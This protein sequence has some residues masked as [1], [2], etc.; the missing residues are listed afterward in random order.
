MAYQRA[1]LKN[2]QAKRKQ[3]M[4]PMGLLFS[5]IAW[6]NIIVTNNV[7]K[8]CRNFIRIFH[9]SHYSFYF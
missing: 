9:K 2:A 1:N 5:T 8:N 7:W 6:A 4:G 3:P